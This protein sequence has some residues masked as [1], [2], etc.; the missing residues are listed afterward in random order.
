V[1]ENQA[2][3]TEHPT[4]AGAR[5][6]LAQSQASLS[7][8]YVETGHYGEARDALRGSL[9]EY[10]ALVVTNPE[11]A[12]QGDALGQRWIDLGGLERRERRFLEAVEA[13]G[14]AARVFEGCLARQPGVAVYAKGLAA[15]CKSLRETAQQ[16]HGTPV[17]SQVLERV[18][19]VCESAVDTLA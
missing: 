7:Y 5:D 6:A 13:Y 11:N 3:L 8:I 18:T 19:I 14:R 10:E 9:K 16:C 2:S 15:T 17:G 1:A 12:N 4:S